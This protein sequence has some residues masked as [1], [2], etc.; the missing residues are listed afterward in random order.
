M[1]PD[2]T[3][4]CC[5]NVLLR[6]DQAHTIYFASAD[7]QRNYFLGKAQQTGGAIFTN[8]TIT[9][10]DI[11]YVDASLYT[12]Q[13]WSYA[14]IED[15]I[16]T[17]GLFRK[18]Y[19]IEDATY[20]DEEVTALHL[21]LDVMQTFQ[22]QPT[23]NGYADVLPYCFVE[24]EHSVYD[25][26][27]AF[28]GS[29][30]NTVEEGLD[31]G[32]YV[33]RESTKLFDTWG[34]CIVAAATIDLSALTQSSTTVTKKYGQVIDGVYS[35]LSYF[36]APLS[37]SSDVARIITLLSTLGYVDGIEA[38]FLYPRDLISLVS[39][40][41]QTSD[42]PFALIG[43]NVGQDQIIQKPTA[44]GNYTPKNKKVLQYPYCFGHLTNLS[45]L[46][47][48][49]RI[50]Y[51]NPGYTYGTISA[52]GNTMIDKGVMISPWWYKGVSD[53][54]EEGLLF[55]NFPSLSWVSDTYKL[56]LAQTSNTRRTNVEI[57]QAEK[58]YAYESTALDFIEDV[59]GIV[60]K[61][62]NPQNLGNAAASAIGATINTF[63]SI[64]RADLTYE[65]AT[66]QLKAG[67]QDHY[68]T[69]PVSVGNPVGTVA[70][71]NGMCYPLF[72]IK[73]IDDMH[74][75]IIDDYFSVY[76]YQTNAYKVPNI[77][78]RPAWNF[79]KASGFDAK[80]NI[81]QKY[82][83]EISKIF[84]NGVT[85]WKNGDRIGNY[86]QNNDPRT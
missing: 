70:Y 81:A 25:G 24:R 19:F 34:F 5:V 84:Q 41:T 35:G 71:R 47:N 52:T 14:M 86:Q 21:K 37:L 17:G 56:W 23:N 63:K 9:R 80:Q 61:L 4:Y 57:A 67:V 54:K 38:L 65:N 46:S 12:A 51:W 22:R 74:A 16:G 50:E 66:K 20:V 49:I 58:G 45:G 43:A 59:I 30:F 39:G 60:A 73:T 27:K 15:K 7:A 36:S 2:S 62:S 13:F 3:I 40:Q 29:S 79:V 77:S 33:V 69:P 31:T 83:V 8:Y 78:S 32:E 76:G 18:F 44:I 72:Q 82:R 85:F 10:N 48:T 55:D 1:T 53:N 68:I 64:W 11:A 28:N 42:S 75:K 6:S 26:S